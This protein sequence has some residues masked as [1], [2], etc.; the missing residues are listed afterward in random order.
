MPDTLR[1]STG[2][3]GFPKDKASKIAVSAVV[4]FLKNNETSVESVI[5]VCFDQENFELYREMVGKV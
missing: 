4:D 5:F 2:I 1:I 3:Y